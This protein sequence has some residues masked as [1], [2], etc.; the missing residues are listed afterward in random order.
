MKKV[1]T[2]IGILFFGILACLCL[3]GCKTHLEQQVKAETKTVES[4]TV[5]DEVGATVLE[6][7]KTSNDSSTVVTKTEEPTVTD[8]E[9]VIERP[10]KKTT[11][12]KHQETGKKAEV[13]ISKTDLDTDSTRNAKSDEKKEAITS[14]TADTKVATKLVKDS[15]MSLPL[16]C[17]LGGGFLLI[18]IGAVA[19][20]L[21]TGKLTPAW[22]FIKGVL[23]KLRSK[24]P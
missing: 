7:K 13:K 15:K 14:K 11:I 19:Y 17:S 20:L 24:L 9:I 8:T 21:F 6:E 12:K 2:F 16:S 23:G 3:T 22:L 10:G 5:T 4:T 1:S 18:V